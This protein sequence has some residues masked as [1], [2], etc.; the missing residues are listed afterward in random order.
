MN[1]RTMVKITILEEYLQFRTVSR[2]RKS[3]HTF[4]IPKSECFTLEEGE[5]RIFRDIS[6]FAVVRRERNTETMTIQFHW[7][8]SCN[9]QLSGYRETVVLPYYEAIWS[10]TLCKPGTEHRFLSIVEHPKTKY[11]FY[12]RETLHAIVARKAV[13]KKF[14]RF[15]RDNFRWND[16]EEICFYSDFVPYSFFFR[17]TQR[18]SMEL[19]GGVILHG[20]ENMKTA[21]Y[22]LHT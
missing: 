4:L 20:Q 3:P 19:T 13:R 15:L 22:S 14:S 1:N 6:S 2:E 18:C 10:M 11:T 12:A 21:A 9:D 7:L 16:A 17:C 5:Q 8:S